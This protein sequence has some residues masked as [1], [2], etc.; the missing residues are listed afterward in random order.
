VDKRQVVCLQLHIAAT[1]VIPYNEFMSL[2]KVLQTMFTEEG[3]FQP[4]NAA[5]IILA[6]KQYK[7][8]ETTA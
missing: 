4:E 8:E 2:W 1:K 5:A 7:S 3:K 6:L